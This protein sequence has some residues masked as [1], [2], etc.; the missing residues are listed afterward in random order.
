MPGVSPPSTL[1][2]SG[3]EPRSRGLVDSP[4]RACP[5]MDGLNGTSA[6]TAQRPETRG[7][8][9]ADAR[10]AVVMLHGRGATAASILEVADLFDQPDVAY[11]APQAPGGTWYPYSFLA[12]LEANE[13]HL[14]RALEVTGGVLDEVAAAGVGAERTVLLGFSQGGCLAAETAA[15]RGTPL[16]GLVVW[17]GG[18]IGTSSIPGAS[19]PDDKEFEYTGSLR[20]TPAFLGCSDV[21]PHIPVRRVH[22]TAGVLRDLGARVTERI[23][24]GMPHTV[25]E[26]EVQWVRDL[27][28]A[29]VQ[30]Q[31]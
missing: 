31:G 1:A 22:R 19:S 16:G 12:P 4:P 6:S 21:D 17:S 30:I 3:L 25:N 10:A 15:R 7:A 28:R 20:D 14:S 11:I 5:G 13:P 18:L 26:D 27:L 2:L 9:L 8:A 23:Y 24:P 29:L